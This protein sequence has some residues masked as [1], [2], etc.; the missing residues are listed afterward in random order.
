M[1]RIENLTHVY[2]NG[3]RALDGVTLDIPAG[4]YGLL[5][6]NGAGKSRL[7][8]SVGTLQTPPSG[9][10]RFGDLDVIAEPERLRRT[11]GYLPQDFGV[12]PRVSAYAMLDHLAVLKG[13]ASQAD[14]KVTVE[15]LLQQRSEEHTSELQSRQYL[16]CR[17]L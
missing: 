9:S 3:T 10:I 2:G 6:P 4:M 15:T 13:I 11:L 1:L 5:G 17:L 7:M 12:Y 16:V 14:R 8:R